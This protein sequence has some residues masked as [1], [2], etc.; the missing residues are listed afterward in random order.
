MVHP[1]NAVEIL[2]NPKKFCDL[3]LTHIKCLLFLRYDCVINITT[4]CVLA[5]VLSQI[6]HS[7]KADFL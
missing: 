7:S 1:I 5:D 6:I 3:S 4:L 2:K